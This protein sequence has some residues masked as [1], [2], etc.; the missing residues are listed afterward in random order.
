MI[1]SISISDGAESKVDKLADLTR[2]R[3]AHYSEGGSSTG[4]N[5]AFSSLASSAIDGK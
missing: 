2:G 3:K 1:H 4:L 5:D